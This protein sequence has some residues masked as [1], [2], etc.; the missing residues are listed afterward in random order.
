MFGFKKKNASISTI[1]IDGSDVITDAQQ[2]TTTIW[3]QRHVPSNIATILAKAIN[4]PTDTVETALAAYV[5]THGISMPTYEPFH[6]TIYTQQSGISGN[7]WHHGANYHIAVK[8]IPERILDYCDMSE[9]ERESIIT[10][11]H[12]M[13]ATGAIVIAVAT[14]MFEHSIKNVDG[15]KKNEKLSFVGFVSLQV[16]VSADARRVIADA[17]ANHIS[18]YMCTG[19]HQAAAYYLGQQLGIASVPGDVFDAQQLDVIGTDTIYQIVT[20]STVFARCLPEQKR[21]IVS[22]IKGL[23]PAVTIL[24]TSDDL[25]KLLAK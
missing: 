24:T 2:V 8:G 11:L 13:S 9:N 4:T 25:K 22:A 1:L 18:V 6:R 17:K 23:D 3:Q 5:H 21:H 10:Q 7:V 12:V 14:G 15:L 19:Q 16:A 20:A